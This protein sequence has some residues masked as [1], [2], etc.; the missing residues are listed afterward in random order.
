[1]LRHDGEDIVVSNYALRLPKG[2]ERSANFPESLNR[3]LTT[4]SFAHHF[5]AAPAEPF[6]SSIEFALQLRIQPYGEGSILHC[7]TL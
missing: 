6:A 1:M 7:V 2:N 5:T 3:E 4:Q